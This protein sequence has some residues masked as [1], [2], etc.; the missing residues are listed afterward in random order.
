M[1]TDI[2]INI[3]IY[4]TLG[5]ISTLVVGAWYASHRLTKVE[6]EVNGFDKRLTGLEG[7]MDGAFSSASPIALLE[8]GK[9]I[10][11]GSG[12][13]DYIDKN[14]DILISQCRSKN[15]MSNPYD[16][17]T[18][19]FKFFDE[20]DFG[21]FDQKLKEAAYRYGIGMDVVRRIGGIYFRDICLN[22]YNFRP[23]DLDKPDDPQS[24]S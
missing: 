14:K 7:R 5:I 8:K 23:E 24:K 15:G 12:L 6:T 9:D 13:K 1:E 16:I 21:D 17:Q 11:I 20:M 3:G 2:I 4:K 10:L 22:L 18:A 19:S